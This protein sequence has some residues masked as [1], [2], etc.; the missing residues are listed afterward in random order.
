MCGGGGGGGLGHYFF[1]EKKILKKFGLQW[2]E[3]KFLQEEKKVLPLP[4]NALTRST[5]ESPPPIISI[6]WPLR[7]VFTD[8]CKDSG[9]IGLSNA[10]PCC[11][12]KTCILEFHIRRPKD[13]FL[14]NGY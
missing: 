1:M 9:W 3:K 6:D 5:N 8:C 10:E 11:C 12:P 7:I 4:E 14:Y 13:A 2:C